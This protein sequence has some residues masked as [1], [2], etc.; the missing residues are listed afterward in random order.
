MT[1]NDEP[2]STRRYITERR[3]HTWRKNERGEIDIMAYNVGFH[4]GPVCEKCGYGFCHHCDEIPDEECTVP[5]DPTPERTKLPVPAARDLLRYALEGL[6]AM[7][8]DGEISVEDAWSLLDGA[9][10]NN[11]EYSI[12]GGYFTN[13]LER[14]ENG[15]YHVPAPEF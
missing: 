10:C 12:G 8:E 4:N 7:P 13:E 9:I 14:I 3:G 5:G 6:D 2:K 11:P 15:E 1:T